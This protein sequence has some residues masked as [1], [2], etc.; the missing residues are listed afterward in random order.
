MQK[1]PTPRA[2]AARTGISLRYELVCRNCSGSTLGASSWIHPVA[3][4]D[5]HRS[6]CVCAVQV[7]IE[8]GFGRNVQ[9]GSNGAIQC[10]SCKKFQCLESFPI[11]T[12]RGVKVR[13]RWCSGCHK[14]Y[15][16]DYYNSRNKAQSAPRGRQKLS[17]TQCHE[18]AAD[19]REG[20]ATAIDFH[21][22][23]STVYKIKA[24]ARKLR[25]A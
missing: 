6:T 25:S 12:N 15:A 19:P 11:R 24:T 1:Y 13:S 17:I 20:L 14:T 21:V 2:T 9:T 5:F 18:I 16:H 10:T 4:S 7:K 22:S 8:R 3:S 23:L